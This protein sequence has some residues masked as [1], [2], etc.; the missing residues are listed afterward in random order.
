MRRQLRDANENRITGRQAATSRERCCSRLQN[1][2]GSAVRAAEKVRDR[3]ENHGAQ[4]GGSQRV[5]E[6]TA[7][8]S[9]FDKNLAAE[10][11]PD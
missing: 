4:G 2:D 11:G 7:K 10:V 1:A 9:Q 6:A 8:N 5:Q 3:D